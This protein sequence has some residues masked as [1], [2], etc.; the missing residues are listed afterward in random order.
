MFLTPQRFPAVF[1]AAFPTIVLRGRARSSAKI[2]LQKGA[3]QA[4]IGALPIDGIVVSGLFG[5]VGFEK[6]LI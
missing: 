1:F 5:A 6:G 2:D 4:I 3:G